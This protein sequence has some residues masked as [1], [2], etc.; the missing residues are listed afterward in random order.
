MKVLGIEGTAHTISV[1]IIDDDDILAN[2]SSTYRSENGGIHPRE[3]AIHHSDN[4]IPVLKRALDEAK[5]EMHDIDL[6]AFSR[7]PGLGPCLRIAATAA[8]SLALKFEL[9]LLGVNHPLG[10]VEIGRRLSGANDPVMLYVSGGNTQVIAHSNGRYRVLGETMDIGLGNMIDKFARESGIGFPGGPEI[11]KLALK[12]QKL[13]DLPYSVKGM[14]TSFS[15]IYTAA[16]N[17]LRNGEKLEDVA[18]SIQETSFSML[19]EVLERAL[20]HLNKN[21]I[22]LAG[23]VARNKRL[24]EMIC[25]MADNAGVRAHLTDDKYCMDNGAMIAQAGMLMYKNGFSQEITDTRVD[26]KFRI[27]E[28][29]VPWISS[30]DSESTEGK[31]AESIVS[32]EEFFSRKAVS[33]VRPEKTYRIRDLDHRIR[34]ERMRNEFMV[35]DKLRSSGLRV[36]MVYDVDRSFSKLTMEKIEAHTLRR[37]LHSNNGYRKVLETLAENVARMHNARVSHGDLTT[38]NILYGNEI[39]FIDPSMGRINAED[40]DIAAD[41]FLLFE[42]FNSVHSEIKG[43]K[44]IFWDEYSRHYT[45]TGRIKHLMEEIE[46]RRRYV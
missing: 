7:G 1:G 2:I 24:R 16:L 14:D 45:D 37:F 18:M 40:E 23:G 34:N 6:V 5:L 44:K 10:H 21:E 36:P 17:Y 39:Y 41:L 22:L 29:D 11:E 9:P 12:G 32:E 26:Q 19:V 28:V 46:K 3:A 15:G 31:G 20:Y 27:D 42:S 33:K 38:S 30:T 25:K 35:L 13:L 43:L 8:R 4:I